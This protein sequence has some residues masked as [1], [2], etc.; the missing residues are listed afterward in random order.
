MQAVVCCGILYLVLGIT[1]SKTLS[2]FQRLHF[3]FMERKVKCNITTETSLVSYQKGI[4]EY[5]GQKLREHL[6]GK[7]I[8]LFPLLR[9]RGS[10]RE[11]EKIN[12]TNL[13]AKFFEN[14]V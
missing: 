4:Y 5:L 10:E 12:Q 1:L 6:L 8:F 14:Q 11:Q 2:K 3:V 9:K 7:N 13:L